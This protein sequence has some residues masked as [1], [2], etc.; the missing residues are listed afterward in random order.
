[1]EGRDSD[2]EISALRAKREENSNR[3][4]G[5]L[6]GPARLSLP[7]PPRRVLAGKSEALRGVTHA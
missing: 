6:N 1:M 7:S 3:I 4:W 2:A 5:E